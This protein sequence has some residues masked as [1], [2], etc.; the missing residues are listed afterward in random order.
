MAGTGLLWIE[1][2]RAGRTRLHWLALA[3]SPAGWGMLAIGRFLLVPDASGHG[4][5]VQLG[6]A[7]CLP[8]QRWGIPCPACGLTTSVAHFAHGEWWSSL[9]VQPLGFALG[10]LALALPL[11]LLAAHAS[12][13]DVGRRL[14]DPRTPRVLGAAIAFATL[15]WVYK[16]VATR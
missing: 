5:H 11:A 13:V 10:A 12:G 6:L 16:L 2:V 3:L 15:C 9:A 14:L 1:G 4:T 8:M 7:P